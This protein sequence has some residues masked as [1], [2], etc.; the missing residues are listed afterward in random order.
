MSKYKYELGLYSCWQFIIREESFCLAIGREKLTFNTETQPVI[1][2]WPRTSH[3]F[4]HPLLLNSMC[5]LS[6]WDTN[7][8]AAFIALRILGRHWDSFRHKLGVDFCLSEAILSCHSHKVS[9]FNLFPFP[10]FGNLLHEE[11]MGILVTEWLLL[12]GVQ[13]GKTISHP[14]GDL[15]PALISAMFGN[16]LCLQVRRQSLLLM[17]EEELLPFGQSGCLLGG[18]PGGCL[19]CSLQVTR[20]NYWLHVYQRHIVIYIGVVTNSS[21]RYIQNSWLI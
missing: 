18:G 9:Y 5:H 6:K 17:L 11:G 7:K 19:Y 3:C 15:D 14:H 2:L 21:N 8:V 13:K 1:S 16:L 20:S 4:F 10:K 12:W